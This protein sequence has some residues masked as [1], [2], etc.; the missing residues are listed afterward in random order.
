MD[1]NYYKSQLINH[2]KSPQGLGG[3]SEKHRI[4]NGVNPL[5]GDEIQVGVIVEN[6]HIADIKFSARACSICIASSSIMVEALL[7][8]NVSDVT[9]YFAAVK[10]LLKGEE[11][12]EP[13]S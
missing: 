9:K 3:F 13:V 8:E 11:L 2:Y 6:S 5:C 12:I 1:Q 10:Q 4:A 7:N